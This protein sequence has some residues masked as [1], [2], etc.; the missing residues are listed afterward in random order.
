[1]LF[2]LGLSAIVGTGR[3]LL[4]FGATLSL[5]FG[6]LGRLL[7]GLL[8][9]SHLTPD[10]ALDLTSDLG[11]HVGVGVAAVALASAAAIAFS[12]VW[13]ELAGSCWTERR[14]SLFSAAQSRMAPLTVPAEGRADV[15]GGPVLQALE[16]FSR[17]L[18]RPSLCRPQHLRCRPRGCHHRRRGHHH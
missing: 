12:F 4:A 10:L 14:V 7:Q 13:L 17:L 16:T 5:A 6:G 9:G 15:A 8:P 18:E 1:M 3:A 11:E 2:F